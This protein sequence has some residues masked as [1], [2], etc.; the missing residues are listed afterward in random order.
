MSSVLT[1]PPLWR[2][3]TITRWAA[4]LRA[5]ASGGFGRDTR[6]RSAGQAGK[7]DAGDGVGRRDAPGAFDAD[8]GRCYA[9]AIPTDSGRPVE[10]VPVTVP[11][12]RA[13]EE[14]HLRAEVRSSPEALRAVLVFHQGTVAA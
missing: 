2:P 10:E 12:L 7:R 13:L 3:L 9:G 1:V 14:S 4:E 6:E 11:E 5:A 8:G